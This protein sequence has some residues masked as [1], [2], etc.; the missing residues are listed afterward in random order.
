MAKPELK[1]GRKREQKWEEMVAGGKE[2]GEGRSCRGRDG[3]DVGEPE[4]MRFPHPFSLQ[5][6]FMLLKR[7]Y[8]QTISSNVAGGDSLLHLQSSRFFFF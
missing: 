7:Q 3:D 1:E 6:L 2:A 4:R 5:G 8:L